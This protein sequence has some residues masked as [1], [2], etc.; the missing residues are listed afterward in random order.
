[1]RDELLDQLAAAK[2]R[3]QTVLFSSH[4]LQEVERVCDRVG[5]LSKGKLV[6]LQPMQELQASRLARVRFRPSPDGETPSSTFPGGRRVGIPVLP[7][8]RVLAQSDSELT[9]ECTGDLHPL[10]QW[11]ATQPVADLRIQPLG[12]SSIYS[13]YQGAPP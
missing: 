13:R 10:L 12:L 7:G 4:V 6:H 9:L 1:M 5:I 8:I 11:L 3:G 2:Q